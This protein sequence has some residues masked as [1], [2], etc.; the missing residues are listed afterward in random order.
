MNSTTVDLLFMFMIYIIIIY[1]YYPYDEILRSLKPFRG[2]LLLR[3]SEPYY[4]STC[5]DSVV[6]FVVA[7]PPSLSI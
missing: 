4:T 5:A 2:E 6:D 3:K 7:I 1:L